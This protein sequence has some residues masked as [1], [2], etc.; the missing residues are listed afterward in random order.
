MYSGFLMVVEGTDIW[1]TSQCVEIIKYNIVSSTIPLVHTFFQDMPKQT[2]IFVFKI[3]YCSVYFS[4][5]RL[6]GMNFHY[7]AR[8]IIVRVQ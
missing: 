2:L 7:G 4:L 3:L 1:E 6:F 8:Y 5:A